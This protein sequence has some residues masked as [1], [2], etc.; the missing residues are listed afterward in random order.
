MNLFRIGHYQRCD[1]VT[2][3]VT[4]MWGHQIWLEVKSIKTFSNGDFFLCYL[5][6]VLR[7]LLKCQWRYRQ[8]YN[9]HYEHV[10]IYNPITATDCHIR[11]TI[12]PHWRYSKKFPTEVQ[13][14]ASWRVWNGRGWTH[15]VLYMCPIIQLPTPIQG[16][17][18]KTGYTRYA[19]HVP[20][21]DIVLPVLNF[22]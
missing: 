9:D 2:D 19:A 1:D 20:E 7:R 5:Q 6:V 11:C 21:S 17:L 14:N 8:S 13:G 3:H 18:L 12:I 4:T 10:N 16:M 15:F 22:R